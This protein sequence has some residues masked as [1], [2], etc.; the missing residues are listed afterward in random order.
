MEKTENIVLG[1]GCFWCTEAV[2]QKIHGV[3]DVVPGYASSIHHDHAPAYDEVSIGETDFVEAVKITYDTTKISL[4]DVF[5]VFFGTHDPTE[6]NK[7]GPDE[8]PQYQSAI[9]YTTE[10]QKQTAEDLVAEI[11]EKGEYERPVSTEVLALGSFFEAEA[12]HKNYYENNTTAP[13]CQIVIEP[14]LKKLAKRFKAL[15]KE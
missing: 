4:T 13:Y 9:F 1:G 5:A 7:Q 8:G 2:F 14:K 3:L 10:E 15:M 11:D 12:Y 6:V